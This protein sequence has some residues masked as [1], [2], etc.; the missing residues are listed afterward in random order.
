MHRGVTASPKSTL[1][2]PYVR[3]ALAHRLAFELCTS[4]LYSDPAVCILGEVIY[5]A[6]GQRV[7]DLLRERV[8]DPLG[9]RRI[10]WDFDDVCSFPISPTA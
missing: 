10:G 9:L 7:P 4:Q 1:I 6:C 3:G 5:R 8:F 2:D